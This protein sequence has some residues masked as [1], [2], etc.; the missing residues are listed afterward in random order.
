VKT[1]DI[2]EAAD[3]LK[4]DR[5]TALELA[6]SGELPGA[7]VGRAWVFLESDLVDY[8]RDRVRRQTGERREEASLR[9]RKAK[10]PLTY[11]ALPFRRRK[12]ELPKLPEL[13]SEIGAAEVGI[14]P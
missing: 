5:A 1:F 12:R 7:K 6:G 14:T 4:V 9:Q 13:G 3:F 2:H 10:E 8:L 11:A